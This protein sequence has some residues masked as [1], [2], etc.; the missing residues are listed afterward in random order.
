MH[1][2]STGLFCLNSR[3]LIFTGSWSFEADRD[4][5]LRLVRLPV[6]SVRG[7]CFSWI[8]SEWQ[9]EL[10]ENN[11]C[12]LICSQ[13]ERSW[14]TLSCLWR[15]RSWIAGKFLQ[16]ILHSS[17]PNQ[18]PH[19]PISHNSVVCAHQWESDRICCHLCFPN[20]MYE[21]HTKLV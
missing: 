5:V 17:M 18:L 8:W 3:S 19:P 21:L 11:M 13:A 1:W 16:F 9:Q 4:T 2:C 15:I 12:F 10:S 7:E 14:R 20:L 6:P